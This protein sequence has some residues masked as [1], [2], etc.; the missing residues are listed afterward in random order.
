M[1]YIIFF[2]KLRIFQSNSLK[3]K[4]KPRQDNNSNKSKRE[5]NVLINDCMLF[6]KIVY[7]CS[8]IQGDLMMVLHVCAS[9]N[10]TT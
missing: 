10:F 2:G 3:Y 1:S 7:V 8:T 5:V 4:K 6:N 9:Y